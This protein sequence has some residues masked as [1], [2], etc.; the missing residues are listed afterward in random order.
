ML[1]KT[2]SITSKP[3]SPNLLRP[4]K[5]HIILSGRNMSVES[6]QT[7][8]SV[9]F[10]FGRATFKFSHKLDKADMVKFFLLRRRILGKFV[11]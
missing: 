3:S 1:A 8:E 6:V 11:R 10:V 4:A 2:A 9:E 7:S 5:K